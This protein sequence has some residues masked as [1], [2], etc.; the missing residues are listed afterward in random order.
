MNTYLENFAF[1]L[2]GAWVLAGLSLLMSA[3]DGVVR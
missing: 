2:L 3:A 1:A